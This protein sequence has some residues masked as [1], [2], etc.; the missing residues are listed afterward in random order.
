[1]KTLIRNAHMMPK[2]YMLWRCAGET[3]R[4]AAWLAIQATWADISYH[5]RKAIDAALAPGRAFGRFYANFRGYG[6]TM[7]EAAW[8]AFIYV[9]AGR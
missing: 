2:D 7:H 1:M 3:R 9:R 4:N 5:A 6:F 8:E